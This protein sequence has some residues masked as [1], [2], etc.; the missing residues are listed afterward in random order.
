MAGSCVHSTLG[1]NHS[2]N[3]VGAGTGTA[4]GAKKSRSSLS[5]KT[6]QPQVYDKPRENLGNVK[7]SVA[8]KCVDIASIGPRRGKR[9]KTRS[10]ILENPSDVQKYQ[11]Q[12][13]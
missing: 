9:T 3:Q 8:H 12:I 13:E 2:I 4:L 1:T 7:P 10:Q 5:K 11:N 6:R